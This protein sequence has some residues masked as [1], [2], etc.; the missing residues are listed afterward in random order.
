VTFNVTAITFGNCGTGCPAAILSDA[1]V[2][3]LLGSTVQLSFTVSG[4]TGTTAFANVTIPKSA[5]PDIT[6]L[7]VTLNGTALS[8]SPII[9]SNSTA[10]S[11][12]FTFTFHSSFA[13]QVF[14]I[15]PDFS[16]SA[17]PTSIAIAGVAGTSTITIAPVN[18]LTGTVVLT[19][20]SSPAGLSCTLTPANIVLGASQTSTLSCSSATANVYTVT[21][22]GT[23]GSLSHSTTVTVTAKDFSLTAS[24]TTVTTTAG[25]PASSTITLVPLQGFTGTISLTSSVAGLTCALSATSIVLG[26]SQTSTLTCSSTSAA[27]YT[28]TVTGTSGSL[29]HSVT[30]NYAITDFALRISTYTI[31]VTE[32]QTSYVSVNAVSVNGFA[33]TVTLA[34]T[35]KTN[36]PTAL[37]PVLTLDQYTVTLAPNDVRVVT[38]TIAVG[39]RAAPNSYAVNVTGTS[40][41]LSDYKTIILTVPRPD[42][43]ITVNPPADA[44]PVII[45]PGG[46][47]ITGL[48]LAGL[49]GFNGSVTLS[50]ALSPASGLSCSLDKTTVILV[51]GKTNSTILSCHGSAGGYSVT[52]T[53]TAVELYDN[54]FSNTAH[55]GYTVVDF[56]IATTPNGILVNTGQQGHAAI[57]VTWAHGYTGIVELTLVPSAGL[58]ASIDPSRLSGSGVATLTISSNVAGVY[59]V[60]VNATGGGTSHTATVTVTVTAVALAANILGLDPTVF[61]SLVGVLAVAVIAGLVALSRRGKK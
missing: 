32:N 33:G 23:S 30:V 17:S 61:Y 37:Q 45:T 51:P 9:N 20:V 60:V 43:A 47:G 21:V 41:M 31:T 11:I 29:S 15:P 55:V 2:T 28:V 34:L 4:K 58:S 40:G 22:T 7:R 54:G 3:N 46:T 12:Y 56:T 53:G 44:L 13:V 26:A 16:I 10:Y 5:V 27:T 39:S 48:T 24:P 52:V 49:Y 18:G 42:F 35:V 38:L 57:N 14:F 25:T 1:T 50:V 8:P 19:D 59:S 6:K 36:I